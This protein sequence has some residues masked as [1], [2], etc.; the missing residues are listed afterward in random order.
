VV[1][2]STLGHLCGPSCC[3]PRVD[4]NHQEDILGPALPCTHPSPEHTHPALFVQPQPPSTALLQCKSMQSSTLPQ[5]QSRNH[6][7]PAPAPQMTGT[8]L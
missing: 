2:A 4:E 7:D 6:T 1:R 5:A 3:S 8:S